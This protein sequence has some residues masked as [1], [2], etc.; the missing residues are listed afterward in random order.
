M[1]GKWNFYGIVL[2][3]YINGKVILI[4]RREGKEREEKVRN[5]GEKMERGEGGRGE[6]I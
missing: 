1:N 3:G 4:K 2:Q 5:R 6:K